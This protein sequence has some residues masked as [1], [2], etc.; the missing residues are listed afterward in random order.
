ML[1]E[2][3]SVEKLT[4]ALVA[5]VPL[6]V[7]EAVV[8]FFCVAGDAVDGDVMVGPV[9]MVNRAFPVA[10]VVSGLV[11]VTLRAPVVALW[12]AVKVAVIEVGLTKLTA[13]AVTPLPEIVTDG[14]TVALPTKFVPVIVTVSLPP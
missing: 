11:T 14:T 6:S 8:D 7:N 1:N 12:V 5:N 10:L 4:V 13:D 9:S 3:T 2:V